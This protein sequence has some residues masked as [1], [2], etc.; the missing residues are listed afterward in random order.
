MV[1]YL[2]ESIVQVLIIQIY[3]PVYLLVEDMMVMDFIFVK[4]T[5]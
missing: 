1:G 5:T 2:R 3:I 4:L